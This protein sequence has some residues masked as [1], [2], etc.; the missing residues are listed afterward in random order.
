M[1]VVSRKRDEKIVLTTS[2]GTEIELVVVRI[3]P[4]K[5]RLGIQADKNVAILRSELKE[6]PSKTAKAH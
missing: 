4:K 6:R 2:D 1:L 3:E 5:V